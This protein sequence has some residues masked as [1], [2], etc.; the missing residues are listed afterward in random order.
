[1]PSILDVGESFDRTNF[2]HTALNKF[3]GQVAGAASCMAWVDKV[4]FIDACAGDGHR[5][6]YSGTS[7]PE[8]FAKHLCWLRNQGCNAKG[9]LIE[10]N[11]HTFMRLKASIAALA[12]EA[13]FEQLLEIFTLIHG[14]YR[15]AEVAAQI[16]LP[17]EQTITF[18]NIDPNHVDDVELSE[19][20]RTRLSLLTTWMVSLGCNANGI[21]RMPWEERRKWFDRLEYLLSLLEPHQDASLIRLD[22]DEAQWAYLLSI[23]RK[24]R[25]KTQATIRS[26]SRLWPKGIRCYWHSDGTLLPAAKE[27]FLTK[28]EL[29]NLP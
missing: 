20:L 6:A 2:K 21:K 28:T 17:T 11:A 24:W 23:P 19:S 29:A 9:Y 22:R 25:D 7:S 16:N 18:L 12:Q 1:M 10:A 27:L 5:S 26:L 4:I 14:D 8:I 3:S 15:S 13:G